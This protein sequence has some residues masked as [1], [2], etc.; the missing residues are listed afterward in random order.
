MSLEGVGEKITCPYLAVA[1]ED[2]HLSPIEC[3]YDLLE[4]IS[5]PK[6]LL[7]YEGAD[8]GMGDSS[9]ADLGPNPATFMADWLKS[10]LDGKPMES[11]H[12]WIDMAGQAQESSFE[13][14]RGQRPVLASVR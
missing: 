6:Q 14:I 13:E 3:T 10:C 4:S 12:I 2:D 8:H 7:I 9:S 11:K 1:G 5:T